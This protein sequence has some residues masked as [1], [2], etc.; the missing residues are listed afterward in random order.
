MCD[1]ISE[2]DLQEAYSNWATGKPVTLE[3]Y[4]LERAIRAL[5]HDKIEALAL[6]RAAYN[7]TLEE[8]QVIYNAIV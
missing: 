7:A 4:Q 8:S 3:R 6:I 1:K 2:S 5:S